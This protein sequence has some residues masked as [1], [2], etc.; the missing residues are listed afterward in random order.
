MHF[1]KPGGG[2]EKMQLDPKIIQL[3][4][5][6]KVQKCKRLKKFPYKSSCCIKKKKKSF[7]R[8][9]RRQENA[10]KM[11]L[12]TLWFTFSFAEI[13]KKQRNA[14]FG[15]NRKCKKK[16][17]KKCKLH[18]FTLL[19]PPNISP[20]LRSWFGAQIKSRGHYI[21]FFFN[22]PQHST[23]NKIIPS[24]FYINCDC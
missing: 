10:L 5:A 1:F 20:P 11:Q 4:N 22:L 21:W 3:K 9:W 6:K 13:A 8:L 18:F 24:P 23:S 7:R 2:G 17:A 16:I 15:Q 12:P 19:K 14:T